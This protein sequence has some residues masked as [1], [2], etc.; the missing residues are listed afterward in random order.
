LEDLDAEV[1]INIVWGKIRDR[2]KIAAKDSISHDVMK[3]A[4]NY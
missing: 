4:Q 3:D 1:E 2:I